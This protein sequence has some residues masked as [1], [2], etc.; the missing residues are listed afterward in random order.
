[1]RLRVEEIEAREQNQTKALN[2]IKDWILT[3]E[4]NLID[5]F[6]ECPWEQNKDIL[7]MY[8]CTFKMKN[9]KIHKQILESLKEVYK[10]IVKHIL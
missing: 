10:Y 6:D 7:P 2:T 8:V 9:E 3:M 4:R 5:S 1:M